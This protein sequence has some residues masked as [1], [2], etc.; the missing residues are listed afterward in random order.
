MK[1][2]YFHRVTAITPTRFWIN[3][4][5]REEAE[6]AIAHGAV[7]CTQNPSYPWKM[8]THETESSYALSILD[9]LI[10]EEADDNEVQIK[11]QR[12]LVG[13]VAQN[14]FMRVYEQSNGKNGYVSIQGDPFREDVDTIVKYALFNREAS[15]NIMAKIP[16][17][18]DGLE[19]IEYLASRMVPINATEVM[20]VRQALEACEAYRRGSKG[21]VNPAPMYY[22]HI[23]G[24]LDEY[25]HNWVRDNGADVDADAL[26]Q[27]GIAA[28]KKTYAMTKDAYP[29]VGFIGG[30]ARGLQHFTEMVGAN[31]VVTINWKGTAEDLV[32]QNPKVLNRFA[33]PTPHWVLDHLL[34]KVPDFEK[35]YMVNKIKTEDYEEFGPVVLFRTSFEDAWR[36]ANAFI[37]KRRSE[38]AK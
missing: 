9:R 36:N 35:A 16:V 38:L 24:I 31:A 32:Q 4:V 12:E 13:H 25:L 6:L 3:N 11:F 18:K 21:L 30:G 33:Q 19:A 27:A 29:E 37:A 10:Q 14:S 22:S 1:N 7:G 28:A 20:S 23:S 17:T 5:T 2:T 8:L 15:P 26:W 34:D